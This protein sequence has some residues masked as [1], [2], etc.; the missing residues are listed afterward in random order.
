MSIQQGQI[1]AVVFSSVETA[2]QVLKIQGYLFSE[3]PHLLSREIASYNDM[4]MASAPYGDYWRQIRKITTLQFLS[5]KRILSFQSVREKQIS[6]FIKLLGSKEGSSVNLPRIISDL[7]DNIFLI[8]IL[9]KNGE[10]EQTILPMLENV[11]NAII[12]GAASDLFPSLKFLLYF[13]SGA[14]S[15]MQKVHKDIDNV[16]EDIINEHRNQTS[17]GDNFL[18]VLL[19]QQKNGDREFPLTNQSI[20][21]NIVQMFGGRGTTFKVLEG[22]IAELMKNP[23]VMRKAQEEVR[24]VFGEKGKAEESRIKEL[25][26][27]KLVIKETLRLHTPI[28]FIFRQCKERTKVMGYD[29]R[30]KTTILVNAWAIGRDPIVWNEPEKF[31]PERFEDSQIDYRGGNMELIPLG[32][33]KRICPAITLAITYVELLLANLLYHFDWKLP[34]GVTPANLDMTEIFHG[35]LKRKEDLNMIP[36]PFSPLSQ[37][38]AKKITSSEFME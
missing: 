11:Q 30:P 35:T 9:G 21:A 12:A 22:S 28:T 10:S 19:N 29:I 31:Y 32:A 38:Q 16:L 34:D 13:L 17:F 27:L 26:Y 6:N 3:R 14:K 8:T 1:P 18:D 23:E 37:D 24:R 4:D 15:R 5:P 20:K 2:N 33:G 7:I 25:K 36:I